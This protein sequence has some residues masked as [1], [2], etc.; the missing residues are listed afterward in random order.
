MGT[1]LN[2]Y[3]HSFIQQIFLGFLMWQAL[4][5]SKH[6]A[7]ICEQESFQPHGEANPKQENKQINKIII[8]CGKSYKEN[9][10]VI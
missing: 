7:S 3:T 5:F 4:S 10:Y 8:G 2:S 9:E 6:W 1:G